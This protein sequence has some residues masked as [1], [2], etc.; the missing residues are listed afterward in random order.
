MEDSGQRQTFASGMMRDTAADK[1]RW[2]L[3][4]DGPI[5]PMYA[6]WLTEGAKKYKPRNWMLACSVEEYERARQS[7]ARHVAAYMAGETDEPHA[8]AIV[9]NLNLM[10]YIKNELGLDSIDPLVP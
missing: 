10:E 6:E 1:V 8:A 7:L 9:F 3:V 5:L 4:W 2:D